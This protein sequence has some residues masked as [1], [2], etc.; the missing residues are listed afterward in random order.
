M[1]GTS[2]FCCEDNPQEWMDSNSEENP[3][4]QGWYNEWAQ[5]A[6]FSAQITQSSKD[7]ISLYL[8]VGKSR[9][10]TYVWRL[11]QPLTADAATGQPFAPPEQLHTLDMGMLRESVRNEFEQLNLG[12]FSQNR[13]DWFTDL[14][15]FET[16]FKN[17]LFGNPFVVKNGEWHWL[18]NGAPD[19]CNAAQ[20]VWPIPTG[21]SFQPS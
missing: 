7:L 3:C 11:V 15:S 5:S 2:S 21:V 16:K 9:G 17:S 6:Y 13:E 14:N 8:V 20:T 10:G 12:S 1:I 18:L 19:L 4:D